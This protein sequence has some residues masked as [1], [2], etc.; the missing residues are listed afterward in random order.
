MSENSL[1]APQVVYVQNEVKI[2][3]HRTSHGLHLFL[4]IVTGGLW[5]I[6]W[7]IWTVKNKASR[8]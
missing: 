6:V 2:K 1:P 5:G 4:T 3:G 7:I 8:A